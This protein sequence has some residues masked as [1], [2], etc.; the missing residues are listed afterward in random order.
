MKYIYNMIS[1][2][3]LE[4]CPSFN[5]VRCT[6]LMRWDALLSRRSI[7][8]C[9]Q[10]FCLDWSYQFGFIIIIPSWPGWCLLI[11]SRRG[12]RGGPPYK[13]LD[14]GPER[15]CSQPLYSQ[16]SGSS[17][18][19]SWSSCAL[20]LDGDTRGGRHAEDLGGGVKINREDL[21]LIGGI[22]GRWRSRMRAQ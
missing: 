11:I 7:G 4:P 9:F 1:Y 8:S 18:W 16:L 17:Q 3:D 10:N 2:L 19:W 13:L 15:R 14:W 22:W 5:V 6:C 12:R 21:V 20:H